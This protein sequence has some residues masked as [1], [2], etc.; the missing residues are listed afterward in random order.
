MD[1]DLCTLCLGLSFCDISANY[2]T[3]DEMHSCGAQRNPIQM[4]V[5]ISRI[6]L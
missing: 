3:F 5:G 2:F 4:K 1:N 6:V